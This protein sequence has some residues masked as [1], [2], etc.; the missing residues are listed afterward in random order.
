MR[1]IIQEPLQLRGPNR[2][3]IAAGCSAGPWATS[4]KALGQSHECR[5]GRRV[6]ASGGDWP[7]HHPVD[8]PACQAQLTL[9]MEENDG[10]QQSL[11]EALRL[12]IDARPMGRD[13]ESM[14]PRNQSV[15]IGPEKADST[16]IPPDEVR[17]ATR[18]PP[19]RAPRSL[20]PKGVGGQ[21]PSPPTHRTEYCAANWQNGLDNEN[22]IWFALPPRGPPH[23][24]ENQRGDATEPGRPQSDT[25]E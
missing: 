14:V 23:M 24:E 9:C 11:P 2:P 4:E 16:S 21:P 7:G 25:Q 17:P 18:Y 1:K 15:S 22:M 8:T 19:W 10:Q 12:R 20:L 6:L 13:P 3:L 5:P